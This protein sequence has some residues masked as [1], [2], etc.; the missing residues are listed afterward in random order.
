MAATPVIHTVGMWPSAN[1]SNLIGPETLR[2]TELD[3]RI[4]SHCNDALMPHSD[5]TGFPFIQLSAPSRIPNGIIVFFY[6]N[7]GTSLSA[8][9]SLELNPSQPGL[10]LLRTYYRAAHCT[11]R[12]SALPPVP[13]IIDKTGQGVLGDRWVARTLLRCV[14]LSG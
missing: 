4:G 5:D 13:R 8:G 1:S 14:D 3:Y 7:R 2:T 9:V 11:T 12:L 10:H 6:S